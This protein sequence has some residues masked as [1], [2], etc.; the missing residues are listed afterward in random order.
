MHSFLLYVVSG[1]ARAHPK[2]R[3]LVCDAAGGYQRVTLAAGAA[4]TL[5][6]LLTPAELAADVHTS[7]GAQE[8]A[9]SLGCG[10]HR[11]VGAPRG[12]GGGGR[13]GGQVG[14]RAGAS[15][16]CIAG[17]VACLQGDIDRLLTKVAC[18][19]ML[20]RA[21]WLHGR[22]RLCVQRHE[23]RASDQV[24]NM[25]YVL[26]CHARH[27]QQPLCRRGW[28]DHDQVLRLLASFAIQLRT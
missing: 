6:F 5:A 20:W 7:G 24:G 11:P 12:A 25:R 19:A 16:T 2:Q 22:R 14:G 1:A 4:A 13:T 26:H 10:C 15:H 23:H 27:F 28:H 18:A 8:A 9:A 17:F 3:H 21:A